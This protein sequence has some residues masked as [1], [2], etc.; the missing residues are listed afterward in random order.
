MRKLKF[1]FG[2]IRRL[3]EEHGINL[4]EAGT[5]IL[6]PVILAKVFWAGSLHSSPNLKLEE[7]HNE[8]DQLSPS[9]LTEAVTSTIRED[10]GVVADPETEPGE[11]DT[12][13]APEPGPFDT[14][15]DPL[16]SS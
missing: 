8:I 1:N 3:Q 5:N 7:A 14:L 10:F 2:A 15:D 16:P 12:E 9:E 4:F 11:V 13:P 6:D